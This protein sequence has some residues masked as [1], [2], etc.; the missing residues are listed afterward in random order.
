MWV[1][2]KIRKRELDFFKRDLIDKMGKEVRFYSPKIEYYKYFGKRTIRLERLIL[3]NYIFCYHDNFKKSFFV[4]KLRFSKGLEY[5]LNGFSEN[6]NQIVRFINCC[7]D[8]ENEKGY[9]KQSFFRNKISKNARFISG[10]FSNMMFEII[11]KQKHKLKIAID[12]IVMT[13]S[14]KTNYI[15]RPI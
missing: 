4:N 11:E 1:V 6:Q 8:F 3:E 14:D 2:A 7:K 15:Y 5:F 13:V 10:P 9:L 12:G